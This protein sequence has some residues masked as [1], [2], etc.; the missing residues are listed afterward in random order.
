MSEI[1]WTAWAQEIHAGN[2]SRGFWDEPYSYRVVMLIQSELFEAFEADRKGRYFDKQKKGR[3]DFTLENYPTG[4]DSEPAKLSFKDLFE[5]Y[6][7][8]TFEDELAD[9]FIRCMDLIGYIESDEERAAKEG[10]VRW[11]GWGAQVASFGYFWEVAVESNWLFLK[12]LIDL[13]H[14]SQTAKVYHNCVKVLACI[15][16]FAKRKEFDILWHVRM[17]LKYNSLRPHKHGKKY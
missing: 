3:F 15:V 11:H 5:R 13:I 6:I 8:D 12:S 7:K 10:F 14:E 9:T 17:K 2:V 4:V 1:N 16:E